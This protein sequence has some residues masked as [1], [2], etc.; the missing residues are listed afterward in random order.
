MKRKPT[1]FVQYGKT[2]IKLAFLYSREPIITSFCN[3]T[4]NHYTTMSV[5]MLVCTDSNQ[6]LNLF[7]EKCFC[8]SLRVWCS[9][10]QKTSRFV[11]GVFR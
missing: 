8:Y 9:P 1:Y 7:F 3:C 11:Y 6:A 2:T 4:E 5:L 10:K